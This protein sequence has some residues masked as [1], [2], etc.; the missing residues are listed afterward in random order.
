MNT[1]LEEDKS[2]FDW[3]TRDI[4]NSSYCCF[5]R[6]MG[7]HSDQKPVSEFHLDQEISTVV[8]S[9]LSVPYWWLKWGDSILLLQWDSN[10]WHLQTS[11]GPV[12]TTLIA[13][14]IT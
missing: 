13:P 11:F 6:R 2:A 8:C 7:N 5:K 12:T 9:T 3:L 14:L 4:V 1:I 10:M